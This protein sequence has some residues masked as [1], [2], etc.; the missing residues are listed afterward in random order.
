MLYYLLSFS[1]YTVPLAAE[2]SKS[3]FKYCTYSVTG[4]FKQALRTGSVLCRIALWDCLSRHHFFC[5]QKW[6]CAGYWVQ[7]CSRN[8]SHSAIRHNTHPV[9]LATSKLP[10]SGI[11]LVCNHVTRRP[12]HGSQYSKILFQVFTWKWVLVPRGETN[13]M[14]SVTSPANPQ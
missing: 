3:V 13:N 1:L 4:C 14:A 9:S 8:Q 7:V 12:C 2:S 6:G 10:L 5:W 11:L